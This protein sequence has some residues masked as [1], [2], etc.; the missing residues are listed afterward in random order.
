M[1][2]LGAIAFDVPETAAFYSASDTQIA[3]G[4][5]VATLYYDL[6]ADAA[7]VAA[8]TDP[9]LRGTILLDRWEGAATP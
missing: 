1:S 2:A 8:N 9:I 5:D 3:A 7:G 6:I 4:Y